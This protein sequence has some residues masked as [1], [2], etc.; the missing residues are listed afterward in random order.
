MYYIFCYYAISR[1][2]KFT[3]K[4]DYWLLRAGRV[5]GNRRV[6]VNAFGVSFGVV[7]AS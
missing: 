3:Q 1:M 2:G 5:G 6:T 7:K 4:V